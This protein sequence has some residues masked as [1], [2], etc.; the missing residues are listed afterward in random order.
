MAEAKGSLDYWRKLFNS[1]TSDIFELINKAILVAAEDFPNEFKDRRDMIV[2]KLYTCH[3]FLNNGDAESLKEV[4]KNSNTNNLEENDQIV[5]NSNTDNLEENDQIVGE[6]MRIKEVILSNNQLHESESY[7]ILYES[8]RALQQ[9][10]L[11]VDVL[12]ITKIGQT[13]SAMRKH[14]SRKIRKLV[15]CLIQSWRVL[16]DEW[17]NSA[18]TF[19]N[20][21]TTNFELGS[22][23]K[24]TSEQ[25]PI[26]HSS[27]GVKRKQFD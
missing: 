25:K 27:A 14:N 12:D 5:K 10:Q 17:V 22:S 9:M 11:S 3:L 15:R 18:A 21:T 13:V 20:K 4:K 26:S 24:Q 7:S 2:E 16:V 19:T 8:L 1:A 6:V 23:S